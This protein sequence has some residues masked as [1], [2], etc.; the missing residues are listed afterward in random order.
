MRRVAEQKLPIVVEFRV[1]KPFNF[2]SEDNIETVSET[3]IMSSAFP[4]T[5]ANGQVDA[6][7]GWQTYI[8]HRKH[9]ENLQK[10]RLKDALESKRQTENFI[11]MTSHEM[12]NPLSA[13]V[14]S[15][16]GIMTL[17]SSLSVSSPEMK[18]SIAMIAVSLRLEETL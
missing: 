8:S 15:S 3:W 13:I 18:E 6:V 5:T 11:D 4:Q 10:Q 7:L 14:Q 9:V 12:R 1:K 2:I 16:D 17:L